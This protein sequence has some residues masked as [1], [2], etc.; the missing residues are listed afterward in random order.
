MDYNKTVKVSITNPLNSVKFYD[1]KDK[2]KCYLLNNISIMI[3]DI[4][5]EINTFNI[6]KK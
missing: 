1:S 4:S 2:N 3:P 6:S 5:Y